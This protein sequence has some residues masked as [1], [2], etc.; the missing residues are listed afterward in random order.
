[1]VLLST[2]LVLTAL[3]FGAPSSDLLSGSSG[4]S[5]A[6]KCYVNVHLSPPAGEPLLELVIIL[7]G[8]SYCKYANIFFS[9][10]ENFENFTI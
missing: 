5:S 6:L 8:I 2:L 7:L 4:L 9:D 10:Y 1:M 3:A